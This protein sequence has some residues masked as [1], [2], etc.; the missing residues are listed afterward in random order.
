M[1]ILQKLY[2]FWINGSQYQLFLEIRDNFEN[3]EDCPFIMK[4]CMI[5]IRKILL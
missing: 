4:C 3:D 5:G 1:N 2:R